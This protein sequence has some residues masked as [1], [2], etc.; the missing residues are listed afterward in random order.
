MEGFA[1]PA[2]VAGIKLFFA[3]GELLTLP[4]ALNLEGKGRISCLG[5]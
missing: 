1:L 3:L 5:R 2:I 4:V